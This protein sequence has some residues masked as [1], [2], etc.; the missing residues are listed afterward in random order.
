MA[1]AR[2]R[3]RGWMPEYQQA[4]RVAW[5][6][7]LLLYAVGDTG[8]TLVS[9][10]LGGIEQAALAAWFLE[11]FGYL[12]LVL[13]KLIAVAL[14]AALWRWYPTVGGI[15]PDPYRLVIP[16]AMILRGAWLVGNNL[17]VILVLSS[18]G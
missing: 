5:G 12:G 6:L 17:N 11:T 8:T 14:V 18:A 13:H 9:L 4:V 1:V 15:G 7:G 10:S 2:P 16:L 3:V